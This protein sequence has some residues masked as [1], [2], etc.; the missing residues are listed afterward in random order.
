M[1]SQK[2]RR[3]LCYIPRGKH[4]P[5][6]LCLKDGMFYK[7]HLFKVNLKKSY[8]NQYCFND[9]VGKVHV[10]HCNTSCGQYMYPHV[11]PLHIMVGHDRCWAPLC[12]PPTEF[13]Y[14]ITAISF[15]VDNSSQGKTHLLS[16][17][18]QI[19][20]LN[21]SILH[22]DRFRMIWS[23]TNKTVV[24]LITNLSKMHLLLEHLYQLKN[25][26]FED[27]IF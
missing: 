19:S 20:Y 26:D 2:F 18:S 23:L 4:F 21:Y 14:Q 9:Q 16:G 24:L 6:Q 7:V 13:P 1:L 15:W 17:V 12:L 8:M 5:L 3:Q 22:W 27:L 25:I 11:V 10:K